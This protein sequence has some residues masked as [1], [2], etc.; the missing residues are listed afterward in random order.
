MAEGEPVLGDLLGRGV[1]R[2]RRGQHAFELCYALA[3]PREKIVS[4]ACE[5]YARAAWVR[6]NE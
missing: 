6:P 5:Q 4:Y 2:L 1:G 3:C